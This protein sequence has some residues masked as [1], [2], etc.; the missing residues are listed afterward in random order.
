MISHGSS[1]RLL[2]K[3]D[4]LNDSEM[5]VLPNAVKTALA[6]QNISKNIFRAYVKSKNT[7][8]TRAKAVNYREGQE[9]FHRNFAQSNFTQGISAK[10][11][12]TFVKCRVKKVIGSAMY[13]LEN[14]NG[15]SLGIFH[16]KDMRQ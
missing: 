6:R 13:E 10:L 8:N 14:L 2:R 3:L 16:A 11:L 9:V 15:K 1:Y 12:P 4:A 7:Y 5:L